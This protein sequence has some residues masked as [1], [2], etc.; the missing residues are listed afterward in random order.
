MFYVDSWLIG[1]LRHSFASLEYWRIRII[2]WNLWNTQTSLWNLRKCADRC[3][4]LLFLLVR[5]WVDTGTIY[6]HAIMVL[7]PRWLCNS[8]NESKTRQVAF[9]DRLWTMNISYRENTETNCDKNVIIW[10]FAGA[11]SFRFEMLNAQFLNE[12]KDGTQVSCAF[13]MHI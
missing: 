10:K 4:S 1:F 7:S 13:K 3:S 8:G 9:A 2:I 11:Y 6:I 5:F 12:S